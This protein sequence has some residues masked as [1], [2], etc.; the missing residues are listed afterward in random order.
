MYLVGDAGEPFHDGN[1]VLKQ[2]RSH[3]SRDQHPTSILYLGDNI[4]PNGLPSVLSSDRK[5]AED[6]MIGQLEILKG[7]SGQVFVIPGNHDWDKGKSE[8]YQRVRN[9]EVFVEDYLAAILGDSV[10]AFLPDGG[11]PGP[12]EIEL[13][14]EI[15]LVIIDTQW[16]LHPWDKPRQAHGCEV[17]DYKDVFD[18]LEEIVRR[19]DHKKVVVAAHHPMYSYG[20][21]GGVSNARQ[22]LFPL[23][24]ANESLYIPLPIIG[25]IYPLYLKLL[26]NIQDISHPKYK[27]IKRTLEKIFNNHPNLIYVSG[28]EHSLQYINKDSTHYV[29][30]G[31]GSKSTFVKQKQYSQYAYEG[32]GFAKL[33]FESNGNTILQF[34]SPQ[35]IE[36]PI[37]QQTLFNMPYNPLPDAQ[38]F[39]VDYTD[40]TVVVNASDQYDT[41]KPGLLGENYRKAWK[42][43]IEVPVFDIGREKGGFEIVKRGGGQQTRSLRLEAADGYQY[44]L[45]SVEKYAEKA[46]PEALLSTIGADLVQDQISASHPYAAFVIPPLAKA[47]EVYHTNPELFYIPDD[48][49]FGKHRVDFANTLVLHEE[50]PNGNMKDMPNFGR[51][52]KIIGTP[53]LLEDLYDDNDNVVDQQWVLKSRLFDMFIADWDRHDD[54]WRW[55]GFKQSGGRL[56]RPIPRDRDQAFFVSE[57]FIMNKVQ[58]KWAMPKFQGFDQ[59]FKYVPGFN[60]NARYFDRDFLNEPSLQDWI[61]TADSLQHRLTDEV[62][63]QAIR[64]WPDPIYELDGEK[65]I[66]RL[67]SQRSN[68]KEYA[69]EQYLFLAQAVSVRG[70]NKKETFLVDRLDDQRT[71]VRMYKRTKDDDLD[72]LIYDRTFMHDETK[73]VRLYGLDGDDLFIVQGSVKKGM[74]VRIIGG[75]GL[76][77]IKDQSQVRGL[78]NLTKVYDT[79]QGNLLEVGSETKDLTS[80]RANVNA[81]NRYDFN[82]DRLIPLI[83]ASLNRDDGI[84]LGGGAIYENHG[85]RKV[86]FKSR[87]IFTGQGAFA[88]GAFHIKHDATFTDFLGLWDLKLD[89]DVSAPNSVTNFFGFGNETV[90]DKQADDDYNVDK[91]IDYYRIR[92]K[93]FNQKALL[94]AQIGPHATFSVGHHFQATKVEDDYDGEDRYILDPDNLPDGDSFFDWKAFEGAVVQVHYDSRD[95]PRMP[96]RG[97]NWITEF[98][99]YAGLNDKSENLARINSELSF[100]F[101][102]R[103]PSRLTV[104]TRFGAGHNFSSGEFYQS[105]ALGGLTNLRGYRKTRFYGDSRFYNNTELRLKLGTLR[106]RIVP[107]SLGIYGFNDLGRV[108]YQNDQSNKW[109][110]GYGGGIWI[111]PLNVSVISLELGRSQEELLFNFRLGFLL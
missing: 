32:V 33:I 23:T 47:A 21:H 83:I 43:K 81:Y 34:W 62:I 73:E 6:I 72:E 60:F 77:E 90:F 1:P 49:R 58:R 37:Y 30:S 109:H 80:N 88:T 64:Q 16:L 44:V 96:T 14:D 110:H 42:A 84:F 65:V 59:K 19:N 75:A 104:A 106:N 66:D 31:S 52:K 7:F 63:E 100:Y 91:A 55:A 45:R 36:S 50:R 27:A 87:H 26:G 17:G 28:H 10:N 22:H 102:L 70:S 71:R 103:L 97:L 40:S 12:V 79:K 86:P 25:S 11:C 61:S 69:I 92:F 56:F 9:Q 94:Q 54:Q 24:D 85:F 68:L 15:T 39:K 8:G 107:I 89:T 48:P 2:I 108:W 76:D 35:S 46:I 5:Q 82:Y 3:L 51:S 4:Y 74:L 67:K 41:E 38:D 95:N 99:A 18:Q 101:S 13:S 20:I 93:Y 53:D 105:Q 57:G 29:V 111:S 78:R 98:S